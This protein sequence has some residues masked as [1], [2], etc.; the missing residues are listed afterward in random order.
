MLPAK[1]AALHL[2]KFP[3]SAEILI[4]KNAKKVLVLA[5]SVP[6]F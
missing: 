2:D 6:D 3:A 1:A 5:P 4:Q